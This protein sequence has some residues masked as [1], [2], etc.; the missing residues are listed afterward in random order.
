MDA[1]W[2]QRMGHPRSVPVEAPRRVSWDGGRP[3]EGGNSEGLHGGLRRKCL[4]S[5]NPWGTHE[6][7]RWVAAGQRLRRLLKA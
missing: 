5:G 2:A 4:P 6:W 3:G 1:T 7:G